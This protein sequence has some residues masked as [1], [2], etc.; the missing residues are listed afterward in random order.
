[1]SVGVLSAIFVFELL[2]AQDAAV[3][4]VV[5]AE[6]EGADGRDGAVDDG[7]SVAFEVEIEAEHFVGLRE[8]E[9]KV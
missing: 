7:P 9:R 4:G 1:M 2:H 3:V 5:V 6:D 8:V